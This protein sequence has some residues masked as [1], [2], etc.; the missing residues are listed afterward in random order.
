MSL[1][2]DKELTIVCRFSIKS[3]VSLTLKYDITLHEMDCIDIAPTLLNLEA[4]FFTGHRRTSQIVNVPD[5]HFQVETFGMLLFFRN[6]KTVSPR[7]ISR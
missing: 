6:F 4:S 5:L 3:S 7:T 2:V 1:H